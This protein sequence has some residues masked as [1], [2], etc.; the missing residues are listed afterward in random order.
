MIAR[1]GLPSSLA[2]VLA[3]IHAAAFS[4]RGRPWSADEIAALANAPSRILT[5]DNGAAPR[6]FAILR[7]AADEAEVLTLA[8]HP[9]AWGGGIGRT[10]LCEALETARAAGAR[11]AYLEVG[12]GNMRAQRLY[13][14]TGFAAVGRRPGYYAGPPPEDALLMA[15]AL[16]DAP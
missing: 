4:G 3:A 11:Q 1:T 2:P 9:E 5:L 15:R 14:R 16:G 8:V 7:F 6:G 13:A 12:T 10:V